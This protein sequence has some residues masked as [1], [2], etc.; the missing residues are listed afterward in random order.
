MDRQIL[1]YDKTTVEFNLPDSVKC[2][3]LSPKPMV[4]F[5]DPH[6]G[7]L[8][9][10]ENPVSG[11]PLRAIA[12]NAGGK[13]LILCTDGT[14]VCGK[15]RSLTWLL[16]A[17]ND[18]GIPDERVTILMA[19]GSH[20][21]PDEKKIAEIIGPA[22]KR[23]KF[24][25]HDVDGP[26][27]DLGFTS[28]GTPLRINPLLRRSDLVIC[29]NAA[30]HHYFAGYGGGRKLI[31][32]GISSLETININHSRTWKPDR[33]ERHPLSASGVLDGNPV[34]EDMIEAARIALRGIPHFAIV[35]VLS[36][37]REFG[38]FSAGDLDQAHRSACAFVD[39]H[40][41]AEIRHRSNFLIASAGGY[42]KDL[43]LIQSHKG[44]DNAVQALNPG[45]TIIY[46]MA[47]S[48]GSGHRAFE[49]YAPLHKDEILAKL[50]KSYEVYGATTHA[51]KEKTAKYR[52]IIVSELARS[53]TEAL[54]FEHVPGIDEAIS[55][56]RNAL[57]SSP[58]TYLIP[59]ADLTLPRPL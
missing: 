40:F 21:V 53:L 38:H 19:V 10:I 18:Y 12:K 33:P 59:R 27:D 25:A 49:E 52:V 14:R 34:H 5:E 39:S 16:D 47:C 3:T 13:V 43:N 51:I 54:G 45:G 42:P 26:M 31:L 4:T 20:P 22:S 58:H 6:A 24:I 7:F 11:E 55:I 9:A 50:R 32:P 30:V 17:L 36:Q 37:N 44:L 35:A 29:T 1:Q 41:T 48:T 56:A 28:A 2:E 15:E 46:L 23:V 8:E 57:E